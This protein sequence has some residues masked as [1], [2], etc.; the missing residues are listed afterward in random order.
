[1][2]QNNVIYYYLGLRA[3]KKLDASPLSL[4]LTSRGTTPPSLG[5]TGTEARLLRSLTVSHWLLRKAVKQYP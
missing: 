4:G 1:M 2:M 3:L 5:P